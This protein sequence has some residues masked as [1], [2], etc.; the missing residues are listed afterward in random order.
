MADTENGAMVMAVLAVPVLL[1]CRGRELW[2][3]CGWLG[4]LAGA[5]LAELVWLGWMGWWGLILGE[6]K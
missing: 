5:D 2:G 6:H 3:W 1:A 4:W